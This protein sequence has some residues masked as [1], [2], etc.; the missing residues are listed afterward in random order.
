MNLIAPYKKIVLWG[1]TTSLDST[2]HIYRA[3][4]ETLA[5][6]GVTVEWVA[7]LPASRERIE[8]GSLVL[9]MDIWGAHIGAAVEGADYVLHNFDAEHELSKTIE[10]ERLLRLQVYTDDALQWEHETW[11]T[12]RLYHG[13]GRTLFQPWGT[14]LLAEEFYDPI[15]NAGAEDCC[16]VGAIWDDRGMGNAGIV[17]PLEAALARRRLNWVPYTHISDEANIAHVR[18]SRIA[19]AIAGPWQ[20]E[21]NYL[22]C[23]VFKNVS[24]GQL[25]V[26]NVR[27]FRDLFGDAC[28]WGD[29]PEELVAAALELPA[30][31]WLERVRAQQVVAQRYTYRESIAAIVRALEAG[32]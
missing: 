12:C 18:R 7:D 10:P 20:V 21:K 13:S 32:R 5:K 28:V 22:P 4:K 15:F 16:F 8:A 30:R 29:T 3:Y 11:D 6:L 25:A 24:Y 27:A 2:R 26:T 1:A 23:R 14:N 17:G 9:A 19:P 31:T